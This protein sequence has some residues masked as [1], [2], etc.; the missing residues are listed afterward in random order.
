MPSSDSQGRSSQTTSKTPSA[1]P[2]LRGVERLATTLLSAR[3]EG[4]DD[5]W[6]LQVDLLELQRAIQRAI[7]ATKQR[8]RGDEEGYETLISLRAARWH[9]RRLGDAFAW[10]VLGLDKK[11]IQS[12]SHN[13][14][15]PISQDDHGGRGQM[16]VASHL[17]SEGWGFPLLHDVTDCLRVGDVTFVKLEDGQTPRLRTVEVKTRLKAEQTVDGGDSAE[18]E[19]V[20]TVLWPAR[21][22]D[23]YAP[24]QTVT[25][26]TEG[27]TPPDEANR[28]GRS[29]TPHRDTRAERQLAR[30]SK[31]IA[32]REAPDGKLVQIDGER[33]LIAAELHSNAAAHWKALRQVIRESRKD[34]Y[35]SKGVDG[36]F[37]YTAFYNS[38]GV[39][40]EVIKRSTVPQD[41]ADSRIL[42]PEDPE[43]NAIVMN[44]IPTEEGRGA[45]LFLPYF[46]YAIPKRAIFDLLHGRLFVCVLVNPARIMAALEEDGFEVSIPTTPVRN[47]LDSMI[48][49][50][51]IIDESSRTYR[52]RLHNIGFHVA[53]M[54]YEF[55]GLQYVVEVARCMRDALR[56]AIVEAKTH[57]HG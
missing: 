22:E 38:R 25:R 3:F 8:R 47:A 18:Y 20:V 31:A 10:V 45:Q 19:Y 43:R 5:L 28:G 30:M 23:G 2:F 26:A 42:S 9:A 29:V 53:E 39:D 34:G 17:G 32:R 46:L 40:E 35:A 56:L 14:R 4:A 44:F 41:V 1:E 54:I 48:V 7:T 15:V 37:L 57:D 33:P 27:A 50:T 36:A 51:K 11:V 49:T 6:R 21:F 16:G 12:L 13:A 24:K 55:K 52:A